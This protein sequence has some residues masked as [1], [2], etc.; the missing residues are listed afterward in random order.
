MDSE[1]KRFQQYPIKN[2][3]GLCPGEL[4]LTIDDGPYDFTLEMAEYLAKANVPSTFFMTGKQIRKY[5]S[6]VVK[7]LQLRLP[8]GEYAHNIGN[9][10]EFHSF[11]VRTRYEN[12]EEIAIEIANTDDL[13]D[14]LIGQ[15][16]VTGDKRFHKFYRPPFGSYSGKDIAVFL[17]EYAANQ[18]R[19]DL[20]QLVGP[21]FWH[22]GGGWDEKNQYG[23]DWKCWSWNPETEKQFATV[24]ECKQLYLNE[25]EDR[26][27]KGQVVLIHDVVKASFEMLKGPDGMIEKAKKHGYKW[28]RLDKNP[29]N[30]KAM[31][32]TTDYEGGAMPSTTCSTASIK[33]GMKSLN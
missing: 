19:K 20:G 33:L 11:E 13:I 18:G 8:N 4:S 24:D 9:H 10:S 7:I 26:R 30:V 32:D 15:A 23:A 1:V 3:F 5:K 21:V 17:N 16:R 12:A 25:I 2:D 27:G 6:D 31:Q 22:T 14:E 28:V 29:A